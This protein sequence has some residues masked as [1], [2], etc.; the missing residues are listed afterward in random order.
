MAEQDEERAITFE[1]W[2]NVRDLG[3]LP[4]CDGGTTRN[5][6]L[7]RAA[8][9]GYASPADVDRACRLG[10]TTFVD[11][12]RPDH[13]PDWR[14]S[15]PGVTV[16]D[17]DLVSGLGPPREEITAENLLRFLLDG[18]RKEV[19]GAV[20]TITAVARRSPPVVFHCHT[21]KDRTGLIAILLLSLASVPAHAIVDDYLA[22]NPGFEEMHRALTAEIGSE[23]QAGAP[24]AVRGPVVRAAAEEALRFLDESGGA[25][26]YLE[27]GGLTDEE[28]D[29]AAALLR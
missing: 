5:G 12:R 25:A 8:S 16:L 19:A 14:D 1:K 21:G 24:A 18:G 9:P 2:W 26:A 10:L 7:L 23:F 11:L 29:E 22:S 15:T 28:I 17:A 3:G 20:R 6:V 4:T 13:D 27:S